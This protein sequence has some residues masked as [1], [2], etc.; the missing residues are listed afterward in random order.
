M[1]REE[2]KKIFSSNT[3]EVA[4]YLLIRKALSNHKTDFDI[5]K[6]IKSYS[7]PHRYYHTWKHIE[8]MIMVLIDNMDSI[9]DNSI[10]DRLIIAT[11]YHD[12]IYDPK[13]KDNEQQSANEFVKDWK[14]SYDDGKTIASLITDTSTHKPSSELSKQFI[15]I[16]L[17]IFTKSLDKIIEYDKQIFKEFQFVDW[18]VY[19]EA[20]LEV[21]NKLKKQCHEQEMNSIE[22]GLTQLIE[23]FKSFNPKIAVFTGSFNPF[24]IGHQNI[25]YKAEQIFDKVIIARGINAEKHDNDF[26]M[27]PRHLEYYQQEMYHGL[28][29]DFLKDLMYPITLVRGLRDAKDF[30]YEIN[31]AQH[32]KDITK[33]ANIPTTYLVCDLKYRHISNSSIKSL[34]KKEQEIYFNFKNK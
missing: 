24:H 12:F 26:T 9:K 17:N 4:I 8:D 23:Y 33:G 5:N 22:V 13:S 25:L 2:I 3:N 11:V 28:I 31:M 21:L 6:F 34:P 30:Q 1:T 16:D 15:E 14:G 10:D 19:R 7:E 29:T 32:M 20:R 27:L 18:R